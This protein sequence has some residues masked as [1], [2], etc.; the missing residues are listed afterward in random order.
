[1]TDISPLNPPEGEENLWI[2]PFGGL[3]GLMSDPLNHRLGSLTVGPASIFPELNSPALWG[4]RGA[5][6]DPF[7][8]QMHF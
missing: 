3:G 1:M 8:A 4:V 7:E 5:N 6:T 2:P